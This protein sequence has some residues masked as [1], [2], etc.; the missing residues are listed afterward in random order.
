M[1]TTAESLEVLRAARDSIAEHGQET[2]V[3]LGNGGYQVWSGANFA[4]LCAEISR[5]ERKLAAETAKAT[6]A[7]SIGGLTFSRFARARDC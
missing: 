7:P 1:A 6:G 2:R 3:D 4:E 5:L